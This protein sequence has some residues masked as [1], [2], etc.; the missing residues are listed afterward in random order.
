MNTLVDQVRQPDMK[1]IKKERLS[2]SGE[3]HDINS[4]KYNSTSMKFTKV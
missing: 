2:T 1:F 4:R 3:S